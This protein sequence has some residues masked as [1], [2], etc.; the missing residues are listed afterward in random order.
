MYS[1]ELSSFTNFIK[2]FVSHL[3]RTCAALVSHLCRICVAFVSHFCRIF[4]AFVSHLCPSCVAFVSHLCRIC[5]AFVSHLCPSCVAFVSHLCRI[6]VSLCRQTQTD[7][8]PCRTYCF[9]CILNVKLVN[10]LRFV[11]Q[12]QRHLTIFLY[13]RYV[14]YND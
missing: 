6:F 10:M 12:K 2:K 1:F 9:C 8:K 14:N 13:K 4:V 3:C 11:N 7:T 5:V